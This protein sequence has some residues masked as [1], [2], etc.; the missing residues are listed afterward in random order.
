MMYNHHYWS[1]HM[2]PWLYLVYL[3]PLLLLVPWRKLTRGRPADRS[4]PADGGVKLASR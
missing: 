3:A 2:V 4:R 1:I